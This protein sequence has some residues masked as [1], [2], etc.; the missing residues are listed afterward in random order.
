MSVDFQHKR[1]YST[2]RAATNGDEQTVGQYGQE[3]AT[4]FLC[5]LNERVER[6][7]V[8]EESSEF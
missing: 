3:G 2:A 8:I 6:S 1:V 4:R 7:D 5:C